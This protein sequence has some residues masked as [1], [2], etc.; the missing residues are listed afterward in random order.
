MAIP[1]SC[2][3]L[4]SGVP[5]TGKTSF[6]RFLARTQDFAHYDLEGHPRGWP[7]PELK[8]TWDESP[9]LFVSELRR[10]H[11]RVA[12]DWGF[13]VHCRPIVSLL[14]GEGV[15]LIWFDGDRSEAR[16][17]FEAR[18]GIALSKFEGQ[19][20]DIQ[21]ADFPRTLECQ[22]IATLSAGGAFLESASIEST[23]FP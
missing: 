13:P 20:A 8:Q 22:V 16:R 18:G 17:V 14:Q 15:R 9:V 7:Y 1:T 12:L 2:I 6:G 21:R 4:L 5:A 23:V 19:I 10:R 11:P 3:I